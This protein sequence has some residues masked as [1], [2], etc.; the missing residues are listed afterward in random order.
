[1][2]H[3]AHARVAIF[4]R[5]AAL[6]EQHLAGC[7]HHYRYGRHGPLTARIDRLR[8]AASRAGLLLREDGG[9]LRGV[10]PQQVKEALADCI[11]LRDCGQRVLAL[12]MAA[13]GAPKGH[14]FLVQRANE[15]QH[16]ASEG[17]AL[18]PELESWIR[19]HLKSGLLDR[20]RVWQRGFDASSTK[21]SGIF[22]TEERRYEPVALMEE[23]GSGHQIVA[24]AALALRPNEWNLPSAQALSALSE[25]LALRART[26]LSS[27]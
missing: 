7:R 23:G 16:L 8:D 17:E 12:V 25:Q 3:E 4:A 1:M 18:E 13:T 19:E 5:D 21:L 11:G 22:S 10:T 2:S 26:V 14:L 6:F 20:T 27:D 15:P 24:I 9:L